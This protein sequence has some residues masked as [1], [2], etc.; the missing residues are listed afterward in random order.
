[1]LAWPQIGCL[2]SPFHSYGMIFEMHVFFIFSRIS[3]GNNFKWK[4]NF[5]EH[6]GTK[7]KKFDKWRLADT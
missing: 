5:V 1:M 3:G 2:S 4:E 6:L 7:C